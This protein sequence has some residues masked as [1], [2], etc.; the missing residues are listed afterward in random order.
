MIVGPPRTPIDRSYQDRNPSSKGDIDPSPLRGT[1]RDRLAEPDLAISIGEG[2]IGGGRS[3]SRGDRVVERPEELLERVGEALAMA[4]GIV[5]DLP[6]R[7]QEQGGVAIEELVGCVAMSDPEA[8]G[9][10]AVPGERPFC[11]GDLEHDAV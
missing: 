8:I 7:R 5:A 1:P 2:G 6:G 3:Q 9:R 11:A 10:V 4:T